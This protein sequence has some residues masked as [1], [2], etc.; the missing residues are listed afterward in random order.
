MARYSFHVCDGALVLDDVGVELPNVTSAQTTAVQ[1]TVEIL[2]DVM[3]G[4]LWDKL[5]W[6]VVGGRRFF[7]VNFS[8]TS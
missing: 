7:V 5:C 2:K 6:R 8:I 4:T 1:L 3:F